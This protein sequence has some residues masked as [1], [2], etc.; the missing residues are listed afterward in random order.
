MAKK[1]LV[2]M[3]GFSAE[4][5]VSLSSGQDIADALKTKGYE[6]VLH[7]LQDV[8]TFIEVLRKEKPDVV[9]NGLYGNWGEDGTLQGFLDLL[10]IPYTHSGMRAS[11]LGMDKELTKYIAKTC[12]IKVAQSQKMTARQFLDNGADIAM[13]YV[14]KPVSDGSSVGVFIVKN[15]D[16]MAKV[17]YDDLEREILVEKYVPGKELTVMCLAGQAY[18]V[19]ELRAKDEFYDYKAKYTNGMTEHV[20]PAE[21]PDEVAKICKTYAEKLHK[22]LG[23]NSV[24]RI[25]LRYNEKDG[26]VL[27]EIN[28]NPGMTKLSLVPEQAKYAGIDYAE[29]CQRLVENAKCRK[30]K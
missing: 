23:C 22:A 30:M 3:G 15:K 7:D 10:Q 20:L 6:V 19:T 16:D 17:T 2:V 9:F 24:S 12:G 26:A 28:T 1:V 11:M 4:R 27:L 21:I 14:V 18:E 13:P 29:L 8:W 25:D 5:D